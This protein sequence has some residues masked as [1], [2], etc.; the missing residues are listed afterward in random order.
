MGAEV[1]KWVGHAGIIGQA[2]QCGNR[3]LQ[4]QFQCLFSG[5]DY[6]AAGLDAMSLNLP[7]ITAGFHGITRQISNCPNLSVCAKE[8]YEDKL[9]KIICEQPSPDYLGP[10]YAGLVIVGANPGNPSNHKHRAADEITVELMRYVGQAPDAYAFD[11]LMAQLANSMREWKQVVNI[12]H[13]KKLEYDIEQIAYLNIVKCNTRI[14]NAN[15]L[16]SVGKRVTSRCWATYASNQLRLLQP[17]HILGLWTPIRD[18]LRQLGCYH[19][20]GEV[21][22]LPTADGETVPLKVVFG[23]YNGD[24]RKTEEEKLAD[25]KRVIDNWRQCQN[26]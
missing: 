5:S 18:V 11:K 8:C 2:L 23:N 10:R 24:R 16:K 4:I 19:V 20:S 9:N 12:S 17:T 26:T 21:L 13:R 1:E 15:P 7:A 25:A 3:R 22:T 14:A 6:T